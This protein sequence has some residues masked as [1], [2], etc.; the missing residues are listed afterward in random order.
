MAEAETRYAVT[1]DGVHI[2]Y[3]A[4]GEGAP[5]LV[6]VQGFANNIEVDFEANPHWQRMLAEMAARW[7]VILFDKRGT[8]L[9]DRQ[10][11]RTWRSGPTIFVRF[12]TRWDRA[13]VCCVA[14]PR[15]VH[16][17]RSSPRATRIGLPRLCW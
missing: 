10:Q 11:T 17:L 16:W 6:W 8:G 13:R 4:R 14:S 15:G 5:D 2:A 7:R 9:S 1:L 3:Q 12:S